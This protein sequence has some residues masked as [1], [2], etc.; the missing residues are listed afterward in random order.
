MSII[1]W[2]VLGLIAGLIAE[3][4]T[5]HKTG[6]IMATVLGIIG[7]LLGGFLA[8][9]MFHVQ[10][11]NSFFDVSTWVT[12][13]IGAILLVLIVGLFTGRSRA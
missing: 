7:A 2:I 13:V 10:T 9:A 1:A 5:G 12:A 4:L 3:A 8:K 6:F 11:I